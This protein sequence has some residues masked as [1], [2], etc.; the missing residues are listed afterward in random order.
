MIDL[1][2]LNSN[3]HIYFLGIGGISMSGLAEIM[4]NRGF[5][6]SGSDM[7]LS[8]ITN[9]LIA[10]NITVFTPH[11]SSHID[12]SID[13]IVYTAAIKEDNPELIKARELNIPTMTRSVFLGQLMKTYSYPVCVAGTHGKTTT[14][15]MLSETFVTAGLN[16][17]ISVGGVLKSIGGNIRIGG[18]EYFLT[19]A[20]EYCNS[21]LDFYPKI[22]IILNIEEDHMDYFKDIHHIRSSFKAFGKRIP[23]DGFLAIN[24][25]IEATDELIQ[26][27]TCKVETFG[28]DETYDWYPKNIVFDE[29]ACACFD[30]YY[31][32]SFMGS[33]KLHVPGMHNV[34][35]ALSVCAVSHFIHIDLN[36]IN[37][38]LS[39]FTGANQR[40]EVKGN[41]HQVT[42]VDDY[43]H[44]PTEIR[45]TL[46]VAKHFSKGRVF[47]VFQPHTY[48]R[49]KA[50][51]DDFAAALRGA[52]H[53]IITDIY[54]AREKNPG[55]IHAK[56]I[57]GRMDQTQQSITYIDD[58][59]AIADYLL[60]HCQ[61]GDMIITMGAGN[62]NQVADILLGL[63]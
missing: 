42:I 17:T 52:D 61:P 43:A 30:V 23:W 60:S 26:D 34:L 1:H 2:V 53:L 3:K 32:K 59:E 36:H 13:L 19:E 29:Q 14:T 46:E 27:M 25:H 63:A 41:I 7:K 22:G 54:A 4:V 18:N 58:F 16:P 40:F 39:L 33:L 56:D 45:A 20:C 44:H 6:V 15:S 37:L 28:L 9:R 5:K 62:I 10:N 50:F 11:S 21:F 24:G 31:K 48:T 8:P 49:T 55:N 38:G 12:A 35:N 47:V 51:L 57:I